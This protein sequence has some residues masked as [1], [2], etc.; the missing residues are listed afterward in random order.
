MI[1]LVGSVALFGLY[2]P[3]NGLLLFAVLTKSSIVLS[4]TRLVHHLLAALSCCFFI[5]EEYFFLFF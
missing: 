5:V 4:H 2:I 1:E 3:M